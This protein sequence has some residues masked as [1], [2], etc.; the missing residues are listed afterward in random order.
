MRM[1]KK[2]LWFR[3]HSLVSSFQ[4]ESILMGDFNVV[5]SQDERLGSDF[6]R[7]LAD[8]FK[9]FI[10]D[11]DL[12]DMAL[13]GYQFTWVNGNA[14][15]MSKIDR[16]LITEGL[17]DRVPNLSATILDKGK[18]DHRPIFLKEVVED[19][20]PSPFCFFH[21][22]LEC[23]GFDDLVKDSWE[24]PSI[25]DSKVKPHEKRYGRKDA[26]ESKIR[27]IEVRADLGNISPDDL[28]ARRGFIKDLAS[29]T[30]AENMD[31]AQ[32]AKIR[33]GIEG[34]ENS[35]YF[36]RS[37][38]RKRR[39][40]AIRGV[41]VNGTWE[42]NPGMVKQDIFSYISEKSTFCEG[43]AKNALCL[44]RNSLG[45]PKKGFGRNIIEND[46]VCAINHFHKTGKIPRG[47]NSSFITLIPKMNDPVFI[48]D[49]R[50][51][52]LIGSQYKIIGKLLANRIALVADDIVS[53]EQSA[54]MKGGE[55]TKVFKVDFE[56]AYDTVC[57]DFLQEVMEKIGFGNK[58]CAWIRGC[59]E[60]SM[61]SILVNGSPADE[62][63]VKR[64]LR[65]GNPLST[66]LFILVMEGLHMVIEKA[67]SA[68][69]LHRINVGM[70][71]IVVSHL[72]YADD[73]IFL[74][75]WSNTN[76]NNI[77][78]LLRCF[79]LA[80]RLKI[81]LSKC[82][83]M[84]VGVST[85]EAQQMA[86]IIGFY[87]QKK[88]GGLGIGSLFSFNRALL[89]KWKW[90][91]RTMSDVLWVKIIKSIFGHD[92]GMLAP[93]FT[94]NSNSIWINM[95]KASKDLDS[96]NVSLDGLVKKRIGD[97]MNMKFWEDVWI[98]ECKL[99]EKFPRIFR[100]DTETNAMVNDRIVLSLDSSWLRRR[101][102]G[103]AES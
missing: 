3:L 54:F 61:S 97:G 50:P 98:G 64:G 9:E 52:S 53:M 49:Y 15:K 57:W 95:L 20:G 35:K 75:E 59:L 8:D 71:N 33:W 101:P 86:S 31:L 68:V 79:F 96:K 87:R 94:A 44:L 4:G 30:K 12:I 37:I 88:D 40:L 2:V 38:N 81:N 5:R 80:S 16:F 67:I 63:H 13:G 41:M 66:F 70:D 21:S 84:G 22:W 19:Y 14:S 43:E 65:Q 77:V 72:L 36:H 45:R 58:S 102:R 27:D 42:T 17:F 26:L 1:K 74:G 10:L 76:I 39:Q 18:P 60:S 51:I 99:K 85:T 46:L 55:K 29:I 73:A 83:L 82:K 34:D 91:F 24:Q 48:K 23:E 69:R 28:V 7:S 6:N 56:K 47:C 92:G 32:R 62:F 89:Y 25:G 93:A 103:G 90:R 78:L 100:L 11:T